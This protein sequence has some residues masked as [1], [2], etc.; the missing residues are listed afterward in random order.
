MA[1]RKEA[2]VANKEQTASTALWDQC[3]EQK[4]NRVQKAENKKETEQNNS[5]RCYTWQ[6]LQ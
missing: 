5:I 2:A 4:Q 1:R 3:E 6:W